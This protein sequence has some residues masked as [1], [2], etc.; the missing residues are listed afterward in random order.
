MD[1]AWIGCD[2]VVVQRGR[3]LGEL[4]V[5]PGDAALLAQNPYPDRSLTAH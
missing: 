4:A 2:V 3:S 5:A 1:L